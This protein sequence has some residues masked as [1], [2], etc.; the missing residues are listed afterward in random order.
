MRFFLRLALAAAL[1]PA[2]APCGFAAP[3]AVQDMPETEVVRLAV[4]LDQIA[5]LLHRSATAAPDA[6]K[7]DQEMRE[8]LNAVV[9]RFNRLLP[10]A[11]AQ[12]RIADCSAYRPGWMGRA[13]ADLSAAVDEAYAR[14]TPVWTAGCAGRKTRCPIE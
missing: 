10:L 7:N 1:L 9:Q 8:S 4:M 12:Y 14:L 3:Q 5:S 6:P 13:D 2:G 11:C